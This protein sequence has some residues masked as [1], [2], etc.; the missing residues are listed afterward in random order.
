MIFNNATNIMLG[1][2]EV[3]RVMCGSVKVWERSTPDTYRE[4][5]Y[6]KSTGTQYIVTDFALGFTDKVVLD[7]KFGYEIRP[8]PTTI[9]QHRNAFG[10][11]GT[12]PSRGYYTVF[13][14]DEYDGSSGSDYDLL[15]FYIGFPWTESM[16]NTHRIYNA[17][18][19]TRKLMTV[20]RPESS[21]GETTCLTN[22]EITVSPPTT[23]CP[24]FACECMSFDP[25]VSPFAR[26]DMYL[27]SFRVYDGN[28][29]LTHDLIP[30][31]R[32]RD[33]AAGLYDRV[34]NKFYGNLGTG[35]FVKGGYV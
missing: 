22:H 4:I 35:E 7:T 20:G 14:D 3:S 24:I 5:E 29:A 34:E 26:R 2:A 18:V 9:R 30:V 16:A 33:G 13:V 1:A 17:D 15:T 25:V 10:Y 31:E 8:T 27:Y 12:E 19:T 28:N 23:G 32:E 21:W 11:W 6:I